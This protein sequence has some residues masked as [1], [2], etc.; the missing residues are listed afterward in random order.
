MRDPLPPIPFAEIAEMARQRAP[1]IC[2]RWLS[3]GK[4]ERNEWVARNPKRADKTAGSFRININT[5]K[6]KDFAINRGGLDLVSLA[7][8]LF[9][10]KPVEAA[11][12]VAR[13]VGHPFGEERH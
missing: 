7:G 5:G 4:M 1:D 10:L 11:R 8:Y 3:D 2:R 12:R 9:D 13:M 6:W